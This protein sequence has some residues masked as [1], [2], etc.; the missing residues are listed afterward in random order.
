MF[1]WI[2]NLILKKKCRHGSFMFKIVFQKSSP[3]PSDCHHQ[4][5]VI[6]D[7]LSS[8]DAETFWFFIIIFKYNFK[9]ELLLISNLFYTLWNWRKNPGKLLKKFTTFY[10]TQS[11]GYCCKTQ[12]TCR[13]SSWI[14]WALHEEMQQKRKQ[15]EVSSVCSRGKKYLP[16]QFIMDEIYFRH[17][18]YN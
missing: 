9:Q 8:D 1:V 12:N 13:Y 4:F 11:I 2:R 3:S 7:Y 14:S 17:S 16:Q 15:Q 6:E 18:E 10:I 5:S